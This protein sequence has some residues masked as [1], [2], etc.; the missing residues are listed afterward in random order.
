MTIN[1]AKLYSVILFFVNGIFDFKHHCC[2]FVIEGKAHLNQAVMIHE[3]GMRVH[4]LSK[5]LRKLDTLQE[6]LRHAHDRSLKRYTE[7]EEEDDFFEMSN[8]PSIPGKS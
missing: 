7:L 3:E 5:N 8:V 6:I 2:C 4:S 1:Q